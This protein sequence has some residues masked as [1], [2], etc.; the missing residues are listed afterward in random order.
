MTRGYFGI[1][2]ENY[3]HEVNMGT[4]WRTAHN[5]GAD[6]IFTVGKQYKEQPSDN[7]KATRHIPLFG[8]SNIHQLC[9]TMPYSATLI[10]VEFP[11]EK[12][13]PLINFVHPKSCLYLLGSED[14]GLSQEAIKACEELVYIP[15]SELNQSLNVAVAGS[16]IIY[17]RVRS[18]S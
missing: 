5:F 11:H 9:E 10:G 8:F 17:D 18:F 14:N 12:A 15:G 7:T 3:L 13:T 6:F 4:L 1:G 2:I 16:I